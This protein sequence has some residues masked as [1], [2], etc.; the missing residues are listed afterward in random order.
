MAKSG[1]SEKRLP[2]F[3]ILLSRRCGEIRGKEWQN[4]GRET[5]GNP[6]AV[7]SVVRLERVCDSQPRESL[8]Q[9]GVGCQE[10]IFRS[11]IDG[12]GA[13]HLQS[14]HILIDHEERR[15]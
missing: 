15:V 2:M 4:L 7:I 1:S 14:G 12:Y 9:L 13:I 5:R 8:V 6:I 3:D 10:R 11:D